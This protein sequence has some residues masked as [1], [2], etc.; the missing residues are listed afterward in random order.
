MEEAF[1]RN[2]SAAGD[3]SVLYSLRVGILDAIRQG[4]LDDIAIL[5]HAYL[6]LVNAKS[7]CSIELGNYLQNK[8]NKVMRLSSLILTEMLCTKLLRQKSMKRLTSYYSTR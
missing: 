1:Q 2:G 5:V 6:N 7:A 3:P 8:A 4:R